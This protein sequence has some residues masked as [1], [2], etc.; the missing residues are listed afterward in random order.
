MNLTRPIHCLWL[1]ALLAGAGSRAAAQTNAATNRLDYS[2][3][4]IV[5]D[6]DIFDPNRYPHSDRSP[7]RESRKATKTA[8]LISLVGVMT[9]EKGTFVFL[10]GTSSD[11]RKVL[12]PTGSIAGFQLAEVNAN[13]VKLVAGTN[14]FVLRVGSQLRRDEE[15]EWALS[16]TAAPISSSASSAGSPAPSSDSSDSSGSAAPAAGGSAA[17]ILKKLMQR[18]EQ[19]MNR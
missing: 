5:A 4:K 6:R 8:D 15:G 1:A 10:D 13:Q 17:D 14:Q 12:K 16:A 11:Y 7:R 2:A 9:Y 3:F 18:R 19:E